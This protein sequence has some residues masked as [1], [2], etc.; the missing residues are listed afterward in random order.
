MWE[1]NITVELPLMVGMVLI[2][3]VLIWLIQRMT[4]GYDKRGD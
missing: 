4:G 1:A 3:I 2:G